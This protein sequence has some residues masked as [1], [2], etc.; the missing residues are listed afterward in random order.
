MKKFKAKEICLSD[1]S[2][3]DSEDDNKRPSS[4]ITKNKFIHSL[5]I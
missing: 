5:I 3:S 1:D 4:A 2:C